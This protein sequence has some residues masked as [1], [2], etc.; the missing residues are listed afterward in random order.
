MVKVYADICVLL[1]AASQQL[2]AL[3][4]LP[5]PICPANLPVFAPLLLHPPALRMVSKIDH[6]EPLA[7][8]YFD[9]GKDD[10]QLA[11]VVRILVRL[12]MLCTGWR[13]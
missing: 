9:T 12:L 8:P 1:G 11:H 2:C 3:V 7:S 13:R 6:P 5:W 4:R 10:T